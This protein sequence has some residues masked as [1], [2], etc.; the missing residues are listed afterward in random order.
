MVVEIISTDR[1][2]NATI[3]EAERRP[4]PYKLRCRVIVAIRADDHAPSLE[5]IGW[6]TP[7]RVRH[8]SHA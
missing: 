1:E 7:L 5:D 6:E 8:Q 2:T 3:D 4:W